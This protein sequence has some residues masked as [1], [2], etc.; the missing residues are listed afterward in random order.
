MTRRGSFAPYVVLAF[1]VAVV[2]VASILIRLAQ[3]EGAPSITIAAVRLGVATLVLSVVVGIRAPRE[4]RTM[5][6]R[7]VVL[8]LL[9]GA[10]LAL[11]FWSWIASLAYTS[12]ASS[13][14]LVTTNPLWVGLASMLLLRE[15]P[16]RLAITGIALTLLGSVAIFISD[17]SSASAGLQPDP[18][19]G[20]LLA[21]LGALAASTYLLIGRALRS[22]V[23]LL[24]YIWMAYGAAAAVLLIALGLTGHSLLGLSGLAYAAM[25]GLA[26]GPQLLGHTAFN[27]ALRHLSATFVAV[28]ILGEPIGSALLALAI[29]GESFVPLQ[30]AGFIL[31]LAGI[32]LAAR[33]EKR[34]SLTATPAPRGAGEGA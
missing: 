28:S 8:A 12:V 19:R 11:H 5:Q 20:N 24:T 18:L 23:G 17:N 34:S 26:L 31:L 16:T 13:T 3:A 15:R 25:I 33:G 30:L 6:R 27:W 22:R 1:G 4:L 29:F 14:V 21:L 10:V 7:D 2:S 9:S 32:Y